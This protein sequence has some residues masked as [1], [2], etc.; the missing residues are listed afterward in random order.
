VACSAT[1]SVKELNRIVNGRI[2]LSMDLVP[3]ELG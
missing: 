3:I 2:L 1:N